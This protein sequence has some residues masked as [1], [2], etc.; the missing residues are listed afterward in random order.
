MYAL[1]V[2][3]EEKILRLAGPTSVLG[4]YKSLY[5]IIILLST[6][7]KIAPVSASSQL[8]ML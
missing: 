2:P 6:S 3:Y 5:F 1:R 7:M 8:P 4:P